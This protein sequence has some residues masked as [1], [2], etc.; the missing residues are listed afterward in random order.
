M[1]LSNDK[2]NLSN[3]RMILLNR[4]TLS[5]ANLYHYHPAG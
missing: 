1:V 2:M 4:K 5:P 3:G